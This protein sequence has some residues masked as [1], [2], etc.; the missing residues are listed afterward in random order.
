MKKRGKVLRDA[1]SGPG[2][3]MLEGQQYHFSLEGIW[4]SG[5]RPT[6]GQVVEVELDGGGKVRS[7]TPVPDSQL[8]QELADAARPGNPR[9]SC[10]SKVSLPR[11]A[12]AAV[13][14]CSWFIL[15]S[16]SVQLPFPGKMEFTLWQIL[17]ILQDG[18]LPEFLG[19]RE[20]AD[21]GL[22]GVAAIIALAGPFLH[23]FWKD[24]CALL[25]QLLPLAFLIAIGIAFLRIVPAQTGKQADS[26]SLGVGAHVSLVV[27]L[28]FALTSVRE[29]FAPRARNTPAT[30]SP[31]Q[32]AA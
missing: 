28:Y 7:L 26:V 31:Q 18:R 5:T 15:T 9:T 6:P 4:R 22:Y 20:S 19:G 32:K 3:L 29:L 25:G 30:E 16:I 2:L 12:A 23:D 14:V 21:P 8:A 24:R 13:L 17:G 10:L 27:C 11:V 1:A